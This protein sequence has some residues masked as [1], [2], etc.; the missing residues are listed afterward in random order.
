MFFLFVV[1]RL[2]VEGDVQ[3][4]PFQFADHFPIRRFVHGAGIDFHNQKKMTFIILP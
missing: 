3:F 2:F 1:K 4:L